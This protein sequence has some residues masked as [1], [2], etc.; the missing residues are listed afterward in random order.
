MIARNALVSL[1]MV[2]N[3]QNEPI[4]QKNGQP[5]TNKHHQS[6]KYSSIH[7]RLSTVQKITPSI[8]KITVMF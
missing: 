5:L 2:L 8:E 3:D 1:K 6:P 4:L 7:L